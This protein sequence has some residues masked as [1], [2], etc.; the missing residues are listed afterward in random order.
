MSASAS[1]QADQSS[2]APKVRLMHF[3]IEI[4]QLLLFQSHRVTAKIF[5]I[6]LG[7][8]PNDIVSK[9]GIKKYTTLLRSCKHQIKFVNF[10]FF[11]KNQICYLLLYVRYTENVL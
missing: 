10:F 5:L 11:A 7:P 3:N 2:N 6:H 8:N 9:N 4:Y 1:G